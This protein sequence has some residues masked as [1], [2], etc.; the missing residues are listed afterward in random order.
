[1][2]RR[3]IEYESSP[4]EQP[5]RRERMSACALTPWCGDWL[6]RRLVGGLT[7]VL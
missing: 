2:K 7:Y 6:L 3:L 5:T 1:M 4:G